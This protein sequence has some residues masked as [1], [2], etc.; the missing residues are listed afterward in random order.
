MCGIAGYIGSG[1]VKIDEMI[2]SIGHRG[3]DSRGRVSE[4]VNGRLVELGHTRLSILDLSS[5]GN[6]PM[7]SED[8]N[9]VIVFNG[10]IYNFKE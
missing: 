3:P 9:V 8:S 10:E 7:L 5:L 4:Q 1:S 6:Q 2:E